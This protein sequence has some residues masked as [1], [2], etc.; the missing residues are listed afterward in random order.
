M[1]NK[2]IRTPFR[3]DIVGSFLR[4]A[5]LKKA[6]ADFQ[7]GAI[8]EQALREAEDKAILDL[9]AKEKAAGL[10]VLTDGEFRRSTWH[11]DFMW[12]FDGISHKPAENG[13]PFVGEAAMIDDTFLTGKI[14]Y[15]GSHPFIEHFKF[16]QAQEDENTVAKQ[17]IPAPAQFLEQFDMPFAQRITR[18]F[19]PNREELI[20]D[21]VDAYK[22]MIRDLYNAGCRNLQ[23]D[24]CS[25][26]LLADP[27]R[28]RL[29][30]TDER[31]IR[32][33]RQL[34]L[35]INNAVLDALPD[36]LTVNTHVCRGNFHST[37]A[38]TGGYDEVAEFLFEKE[39]VNA[40]YLEYDTDRAGGF[41]PLAKVT[42]GK[43][44]VLG[45]ITTKF[46]ELEAQDAIIA[47][48]HE[49]AK[50][51]S[52]DRLYLSPQCGFASCEIGNK[53]TEDEQWAKIRLVKEIAEK[54]W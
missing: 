32:K 52:L 54:V 19:Y 3:Y 27:R 16:V 39:H 18:Q 43:K 37:Y 14:R 21:I 48:I 9:I 1:Q 33:I 25:W 42:D 36:D 31:G 50:Y 41:E 17:T 24:D 6:R 34:Y 11:L 29:F 10:H 45:L 23:L 4:P 30:G 2:T 53:L 47:R 35:D 40:Y 20:S 49:A 46:P 7:S 12:A 38:A 13:L 44:V 8:S 28:E 51:I 22:A 5:A 26:G 15:T